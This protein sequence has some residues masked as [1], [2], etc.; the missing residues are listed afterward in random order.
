MLDMQGI[1]GVRLY[2]VDVCL[3]EVC[4][5]E[6]GM[7]SRIPDSDSAVTTEREMA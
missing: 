3:S 2:Q 7:I 1:V 4:R 6:L 5:S